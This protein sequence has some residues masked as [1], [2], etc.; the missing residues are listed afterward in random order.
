MKLV[1]L[2]LSATIGIILVGAVMVPIINDDSGSDVWTYDD[3]READGVASVS[4]ALELVTVGSTEYVHAS[5]VGNATLTYTDGSSETVTVNKADLS[6]LFI[7]GQSNGEY[8]TQYAD[9]DAADPVPGL[10]QAYY[11][12]T[13]DSP[14]IKEYTAS[15]C[16]MHDM[17][18]SDGSL[19]VGDIWPSLAASYTDYCGLKA[20][21]VSAAW[22][23]KSITEFTPGTGEIWLYSVQVLSDAIDA[24][25]T[26]LYNLTID[27]YIWIQGEADEDMVKNEYINRFVAMNDA[28]LAGDLGVSSIDAC[29]ISKVREE[30]APVIAAAQLEICN[31]VSNVYMACQLADDFTYS[32]GYRADYS[33]YTQAGD[34]LIGAAVGEYIANHYYPKIEGYDGLVV[35]IPAIVILAIISAFAVAIYKRE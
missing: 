27:S 12:G 16:A 34:N 17:I 1:Y 22:G 7:M 26:S 3:Y 25:D 8:L 11:Y 13:D 24:V 2:I 21:V 23:G 33:H 6:M 20:Y 10:G 9:P 15:D 4:G 18:D 5:S 32:N 31:T 28:I 19:I 14:T 30:R 29:F 35:V